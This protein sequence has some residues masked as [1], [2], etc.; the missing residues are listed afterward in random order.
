MHRVQTK[1]KNLPRENSKT[2]IWGC[3]YCVHL[4]LGETEGRY[5]YEQTRQDAERSLVT[6]TLQLLIDGQ[7]FTL[8]YFHDYDDG[9]LKIMLNET[10]IDATIGRDVP[11]ETFELLL[12]RFEFIDELLKGRVVAFAPQEPARHD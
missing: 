2:D 10:L 5:I 1:V 9:S 3:D 4:L 6:E 11:G 7:L 12:K 8:E